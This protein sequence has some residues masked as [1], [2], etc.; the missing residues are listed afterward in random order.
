M[1][2]KGT[3]YCSFNKVVI[4]DSDEAER[5]LVN[6]AD[7][8]IFLGLTDFKPSHITPNPLDNNRSNFLL[9]MNGTGEN[10]DHDAF[11]KAFMSLSASPACLARAREDN[12]VMINI[13][14]RFRVELN[15]CKSTKDVTTVAIPMYLLR[16]IHWTV[17]ELDL[18]DNEYST[19]YEVYYGGMSPTGPN[20]VL[21]HLRLS[22]L[23]TSNH[24]AQFDRAIE[25]YKR[26][27]LLAGWVLK[28]EFN[29]LPV[30]SIMMMLTRAFAVA[31]LQGPLDTLSNFVQRT[32]IPQFY[33]ISV[34]DRLDDMWKNYSQYLLKVS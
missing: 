29:M 17:L 26:S 20:S 16:V 18:I 12:P 5:L 28:P 9:T 31:G 19:L 14:N 8:G 25:I 32:V 22:N 23:I 2:G 34:K 10:N 7:R 13:M 33:P 1:Y 11:R 30:S 4:T 15:R 3:A 24:I 6:P 21:W 27:P